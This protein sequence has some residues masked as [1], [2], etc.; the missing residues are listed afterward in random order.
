MLTVLAVSVPHAC[1]AAEA[2]FQVRV[3]SCAQVPDHLARVPA[4][5]A[6]LEDA[7]TEELR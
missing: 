3:I 2:G 7:A 4:Q 5:L 1:R 6:A